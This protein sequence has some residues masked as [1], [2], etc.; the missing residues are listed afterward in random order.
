[1]STENKTPRGLRNHNP[2]NI[3]RDAHTRW[4]GTSSIQLDKTFLQ[5]INSEYGWRAAFII[6]RKYFYRYGLNTIA[7]IVSK[8]APGGENNTEAYIA[9][10]CRHTGLS[11]GQDLGSP[12]ANIGRWLSVAYAMAI[13][14]NGWTDIEVMP[15]LKGYDLAVAAT[16]NLEKDNL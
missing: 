15:M 16:R 13:V 8:W 7:D 6:L 3:K 10:V 4:I 1:M 14:E 2:L 12:H 9:A 11:A 5:F